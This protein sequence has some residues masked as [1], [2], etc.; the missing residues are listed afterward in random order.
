MHT[1]EAA[2]AGCM[3]RSFG[4]SYRRMLATALTVLLAIGVLPANAQTPE[5]L[6]L[7]RRGAFVEGMQAIVAGLNAGSSEA[8][9]AATR[10][11]E[12]LERIFGLR[13]I[14]QRVKRQFE[15]N[16]EFSYSDMLESA[17]P[18]GEGGI[19]AILLGL[20]SRGERG[21][22]VI[23][24][25]LPDFQ[26]NYHEY[27]LHLDGKGRVVID[28]WTDYLQ[29]ERFSDGI[30]M[31]LIKAAPTRPAMRK[32]IDFQ[33]VRD[34]E[35]FQFTE[36]LKA[37]RDRQVDRYVEIIA[38]LNERM[39]SQRVVVLTSVQ[40]AK[41]LRNRRM[42]RTALTQ[43]AQ[44]YPEATEFS[45]LLLDYYFPTR[46]YDAALQALLRLEE[47]LGFA[48]SGMRARLSAAT[49]VMGNVAEAMS[50]ADTAL[51]LEPTLELAWWSALRARAAANEYALAVEALGTLETRFG[52]TL[53]RA[54]LERDRG[55]AGLLASEE[56]AVWRENE[57]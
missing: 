38:G 27:D 41:Q 13:L 24:F 34:S 44:H 51:E 2:A 40:L 39:Q 35:L 11:D 56:Y 8:F 50:Y 3:R 29:G 45:L 42:L 52:H 31:M 22:A 7:A 6:E 10:Q 19:K 26:F 28:D 46:Q 1:A 36:L 15:E 47:R 48:D 30:G 23:R 4:G 20:E 55:L 5:E 53:D 32:L 9:I 21:R 43:M 18:R 37:S 25:D 14:D 54:A 33:N 16:L 17:L 49:L 57:S 12:L